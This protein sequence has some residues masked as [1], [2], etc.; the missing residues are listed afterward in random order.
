MHID[1]F[2]VTTGQLLY[3]C[4]ILGRFQLHFAHLQVP[5]DS[6]QTDRLL[7]Y[8]DDKTDCRLLTT[9]ASAGLHVTQTERTARI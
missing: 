1:I 9:D 2:T 3:L 8:H 7:E 5:V 4:N 6:S